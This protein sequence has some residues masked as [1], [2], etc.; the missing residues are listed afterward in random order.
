MNAAEAHL[1]Q[2]SFG[3][4]AGLLAD[5][6]TWYAGAVEVLGVTPLP[7]AVNLDAAH[8]RVLGRARIDQDMVGE[9]LPHGSAS[10]VEPAAGFPLRDKLWATSLAG[11]GDSALRQTVVDAF[12]LGGMP[13]FQRWRLD[14]EH[15]AALAAGLQRLDGVFPELGP[16]TLDFVREVVV[17]DSPILSAYVAQ[18]PESIFLGSRILRKSPD[19]IAEALLHE[20][21]HEKSA[22][23]RLARVLFAP[24][25]AEE[26]S[27]L[28]TLP[29]T[30]GGGRPRRFSAWRLLSAAHVYTHLAIFCSGESVSA[31]S[32]A[33]VP[34]YFAR[35]SLM[36][37]ALRTKT[38][39]RCLGLDGGSFVDFLLRALAYLD[40]EPGYAIDG[41]QITEPATAQ[42]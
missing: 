8:R 26:T 17:H 11:E 2:G 23:I 29:W 10:S 38:F 34:E 12:E 31:E 33:R 42:H 36:L 1:T 21:L 13:P 15:V 27:P 35:G 28:L 5:R 14:D 37:D 22:V 32:R 30:R 40:I 18:V 25:Y 24:G 20:S 7:E 39:S 41:Q 6:D 19:V 9:R 4:P 3:D 16:T